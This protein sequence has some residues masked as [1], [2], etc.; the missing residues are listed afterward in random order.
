M[1]AIISF[2]EWEHFNGMGRVRQCQVMF[3]TCFEA[4]DYRILEPDNKSPDHVQGFLILCV[5]LRTTEL[6]VLPAIWDYRKF[7]KSQDR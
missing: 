6:L 3:Q 5:C 4:V 1:T 7:D 2:N